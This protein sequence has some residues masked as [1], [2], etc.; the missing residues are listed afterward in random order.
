MFVTTYTRPG[1][2][3]GRREKIMEKALITRNDASK[4]L[5]VSLPV[6]D[7]WLRR[8]DNPLPC[9]RAGRKVLIPADGLSRWIEEETARNAMKT[10]RPMV[11]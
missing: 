2:D 9:I 11:R 4:T 1:G 8:A 7:A 5:N 10:G 3:E 6:L